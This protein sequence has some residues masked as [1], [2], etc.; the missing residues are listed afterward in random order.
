MTNM[1]DSV[2]A[3]GGACSYT[4][5]K[6]G[7]TLVRCSWVIKWG[8]K[9]K[10]ASRP[11]FGP[12]FGVQLYNVTIYMHRDCCLQ[13]LVHISTH[14]ERPQGNP[15]SGSAWMHTCHLQHLNVH[16]HSCIPLFITPPKAHPGTSTGWIALGSFPMGRY[17]YQDVQTTIPMHVGSHIVEL[18]PKHWPKTRPGR[19]FDLSTPFKHPRTSY[20]V[21]PQPYIQ[22]R[23]TPN[24]LP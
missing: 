9:V 4:K 6:V 17:M 16:D 5:Y 8:R 11:S 12:V 2:R 23:N 15:S 13:I 18:D 14:R 1:H 21:C 10:N 7:D 19:I 24:P 3:M 20:K 22:Y